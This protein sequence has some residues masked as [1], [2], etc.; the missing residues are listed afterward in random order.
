MIASSRSPST[1]S[2][3]PL[4]RTPTSVLAWCRARP[5]EALLLGLCAGVLIYFFGFFDA[6]VKGRLSTV[7]WASQAWNKENNQEHSWLVLPI[8]LGLFWYHRRRL[9]EAVGEPWNGGL[10]IVAFGVA[11]FVLAVRALQP[12]IAI[13][14][15]PLIVF[16]AIAFLAGKRCARVALFPC[17]FM[18]L[19][20]PIGGLVQ[21]TVSLQ[22]LVST[23]CNALASFLGMKIAASG[24][25]IHALD[26]S[27][28][29]EIA[30][31]CS[32][33]RSLMAMTMLTALYVHFTQREW[34]KKGVIFAGS[35]IFAVVGNI[36][37]IFTVIL[38]AK[39][40]SPRIAEGI[41][42][43][44]SA[45][46][47][48]PFAVISMVSFSHLVNLDWTKVIAGRNLTPPPAPPTADDT[49]RGAQKP[50]APVSYDY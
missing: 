1:T 31:G 49:A 24:T 37:R 3:D 18:L 38:F 12:R 46:I 25:T 26:G 21:G 8:T 10:G 20:I 33:I 50:A 41:Y 22:I 28:N 2:P 45:F 30:E 44:Y 17:A 36:G 47:F 11:T 6:F 5:V 23:V 34:W 48:F 39:F 7:V 9:A 29:F 35:L 27:F 42:H 14:A 43:D 16:G 4:E 32:G 15:F 19:M 13:F 40:I